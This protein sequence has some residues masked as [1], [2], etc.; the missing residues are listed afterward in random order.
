MSSDSSE[1][2]NLDLLREAVDSQFFNE[3]MFTENANNAVKNSEKTIQKNL[4]PSLR[5][6]QDDD[7]QF[8][9][10]RVTPE[11]QIYVAKHLSR[12]LEEKLLTLLK[13]M[14]SIENSKVKKHKSGV[15]LFR[16]SKKFLK[17]EK[18]DASLVLNKQTISVKPRKHIQKV[19]EEDIKSLAISPE[20]ILNKTET[21]HWSTRSKAPV[22]S[23]K[24]VSNGTLTLIEPKFH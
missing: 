8:N 6:V 14:K 2:E 7:E 16:D 19:D 9:L 21:E 10:F 11:F 17:I 22:Y 23:Y 4:P 5:K 12:A 15:K 18:Y 1:D 13:P 20:I 3:S 24:R